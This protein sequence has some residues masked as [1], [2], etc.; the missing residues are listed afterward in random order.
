M[1]PRLLFTGKGSTEFMTWL[2]KKVNIQAIVDLPDNMFSSQIQQKSIL[3][4]QNHGEKAVEREV[5]VAKLDS[6]KKPDSLVAFNMKLNDWY[7][8]NKD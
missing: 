4:F 2:A 3:V 6:L 5:L 8:K 1:V 7:D